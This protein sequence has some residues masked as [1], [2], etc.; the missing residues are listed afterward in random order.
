MSV[1]NLNHLYGEN[2]SV[3]IEKK[4]KRNFE[5]I[6]KESIAIKEEMEHHVNKSLWKLAENAYEVEVNY[7]EPK[8]KEFA[9]A[10]GENYSTVL[11]WRSVYK[12]YQEIRRR[13][14]ELANI[15][16]EKIPFWSWK[17]L[18]GLSTDEAVEIL[19]EAIE[20]DLSRREIRKLVRAFKQIEKENLEDI[21]LREFENID[22]SQIEEIITKIDELIFAIAQFN[23]FETLVKKLEEYRECLIYVKRS[24]SGVYVEGLE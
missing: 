20:K 11:G 18:A 8:L 15:A 7:K 12:T 13:I 23:S 6:V 16:R 22:I 10:I 19:K 14:S 9:E 17:E 2:M 24:K 3:L 1:M 21:I 5:E 4:K